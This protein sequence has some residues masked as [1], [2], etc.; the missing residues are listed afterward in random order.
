MVHEGVSENY[1]HFGLMYTEDNILLVLPLKYL[2]NEDG[3]T[4]TP[5]KIAT[6]KKPSI[7]HL[8]VLFY[9]CAV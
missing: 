5:F 7:L 1:I 2:I 9:P 4:T 3:N 8:R 6:G